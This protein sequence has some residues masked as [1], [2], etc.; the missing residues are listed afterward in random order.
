MRKGGRQ[1][2]RAAELHPAGTPKLHSLQ[3]L[4]VL[5]GLLQ[6]LFSNLPSIPLIAQRAQFR[7]DLL[8]FYTMD[9]SYTTD[10]KTSVSKQAGALFNNDTFLLARSETSKE[11]AYLDEKAQSAS[12]RSSDELEDAEDYLSGTRLGVITVSLRQ[13]THKIY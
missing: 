11:Q 12:S 5:N 7:S 6:I 10:G 4:R 1:R 13:L 2:L 3:G 9:A 8:S